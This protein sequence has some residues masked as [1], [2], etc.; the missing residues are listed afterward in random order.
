MS[1]PD[2]SGFD[3]FGDFLIIFLGLGTLFQT[4]IF[5]MTKGICGIYG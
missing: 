3:K 2:N 4:Y 1:K 5:I